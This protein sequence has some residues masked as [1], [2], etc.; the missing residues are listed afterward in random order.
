MTLVYAHLIMLA[1]LLGYFG[2]LTG[3]HGRTVFALNDFTLYEY[4]RKNKTESRYNAN[5]AFI[6]GPGDDRSVYLRFH[7]WRQC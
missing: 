2:C 6:D 5:F 4:I 3:P 7:K 1:F